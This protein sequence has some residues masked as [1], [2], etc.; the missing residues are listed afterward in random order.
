MNNLKHSEHMVSERHTEKDE[1]IQQLQSKLRRA[2]QDYV[3]ILGRWR[4][5]QE[6]IKHWRG[7]A[8]AASRREELRLRQYREASS[9]LESIRR[10]VKRIVAE[11]SIDEHEREWERGEGFI[12][13]LVADTGEG[14]DSRSE[15]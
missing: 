7:M 5:A 13:L 12:A 1:Q 9:R 10:T 15:S 8:E 6:S 4:E 14:Q 11:R 2:E 3:N